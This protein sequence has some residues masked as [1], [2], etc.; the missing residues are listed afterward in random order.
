M[1]KEGRWVSP[2]SSTPGWLKGSIRSTNASLSFLPI[3]P[4]LS[5]NSYAKLYIIDNCVYIWHNCHVAPV[6]QWIEHL[7]SDQ[8]VAGSSPAW[9]VC[10]VCS[11]F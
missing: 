5:L 2:V 4:W 10:L 3:S 11:L 7:T 8:G 9:C 1:G 6:A